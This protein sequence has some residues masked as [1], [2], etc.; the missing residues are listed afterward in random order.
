M[1]RRYLVVN[2]DSRTKEAGARENCRPHQTGCQH[3]EQLEKGWS[4]ARFGHPHIYPRRAKFVAASRNIK[5]PI[6][7][8]LLLGVFFYVYPR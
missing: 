8:Q 5:S 4:E 3:I 1:G 6:V 2:V 7:T